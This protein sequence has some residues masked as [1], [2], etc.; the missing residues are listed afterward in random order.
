M[1]PVLQA[2][3]DG[4]ELVAFR[5]DPHFDDNG[6]QV[7]RHDALVVGSGDVVFGTEETPSALIVNGSASILGPGY[8]RSLTVGNQVVVGASG[9]ADVRVLGTLVVGQ[10]QPQWPLQVGDAITGLGLASGDGTKPDAGF[11]RFGDG[12]GWKLHIAR[13]QNPDGSELSAANSA[14]M[15]LIDAPG[16]VGI[17]TTTPAARLHVASSGATF[18]ALTTQ[19][20]FRT[21]GI[22]L[23]HAPNNTLFISGA[24]NDRVFFFWKDANGR[25]Y[26]ASLVATQDDSVVVNV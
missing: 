3:A 8:V 4:V 16:S 11:L 1:Q 12:T 23:A 5:I 26:G 7:L 20:A 9:P 25:R 19:L 21:A 22:Q 13:A 6:K 24:I 17:G 15:T 2:L 18:I 14:V 10:H